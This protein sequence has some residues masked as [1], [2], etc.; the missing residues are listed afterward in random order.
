MATTTDALIIGGGLHGLST[1]LHLAQAG[2]RVVVL[3]KDSVGRHASS[4]NAGGVRQLGRDLAEIP[5]ALAALKRWHNIADMVGDDCGFVNAG[6]IKVA[7]TDDHLLALKNRSETVRKL[8]YSHEEIIGSQELYDQLPALAPGCVG[9]MIVRSDG[10][11]NPF[12]TVQ[13]FRRKVLSLGVEIIEH[14]PLTAITKQAGVWQAKTPQGDFEAPV[15]VNAAGAWGGEVAEMLGDYAPV[16]AQALML[17]ITERLTPFIGPVVG[18]QGRSLSFKQFENGTVLI[19]GAYQGR[20]EPAHNKTHLDF[21]GLSQNAAAAAAIFPL[22]RRANILRCWAGIEGHLPDNIPAIGRGAEDGAFHA[23]GFSA[24]GFALA[25]IV[26][27]I[28]A[29][30]IVDGASD[31]PVSDFS[32]GRFS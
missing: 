12:R 26:G 5:L 9:G 11:A 16:Q 32:I 20:A 15:V 27:K 21:E 1:A 30:L 22:M 3:E 10:H 13:A 6:Q 25:P 29:D 17:M 8:G 31:L 2:L 24:H 4:A 7:E 18:A 23:F 28:V 19:G 14:T